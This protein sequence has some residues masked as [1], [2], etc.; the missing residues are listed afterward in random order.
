[1]PDTDT[2]TVEE[3]IVSS[4][5]RDTPGTRVAFFLQ[6][7]RYGG[8]QRVTINIANGL[9]ARGYDVDLVVANLEGDFTSDVSDELNVVELAVPSVAGLGVLAGIP[10][11]KA[12]LESTHPA[13]LIAGQT[14]ANI[15][16]ALAARAAKPRP[17]VALTEHSA[18]GRSEGV[19]DWLTNALAS[20]VY[21]L[22]DDIVGVSEGVVESIVENTRITPTNTSVLYNPIDLETVR[23]RSKDPVTHD[24]LTDPSIRPVVSVSRLETQKNLSLLLRAFETVHERYPDTRLI[25]VGKGS[26]RDRLDELSRS[27]GIDDV[28]AFPGYDDNPYAYRR[29]SAVF[30]LSSH[31]EGLPTVLIEALA[32]GCSIVSTDC[33]YGP[34]EILVDG[35][36]GRLTP[37][38]DEAAL[39]E[40]IGATL[41]NPVDPDRSI[42]RSEHFSMANGIDRYEEYI[43]ANAG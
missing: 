13:V 11:L 19:K 39:A 40:A 28:V 42:E 2:T 1:M 27:L 22:A 41:D 31:Y 25:V 10:R 29:Q 34:R 7:L 5:R 3:T 9:T 21:T 24:W 43:L 30:V 33:P 8:A 14:H 36:F 17:Y 18:Y 38:D 12:Y 37:V 35:E 32:C 6:N 26:E 16:A 4:E 15:A 23:A 20:Y